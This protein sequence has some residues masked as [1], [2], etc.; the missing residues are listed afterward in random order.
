[1]AIRV[2]TPAIQ[3]PQQLGVIQAQAT[4]TPFQNL[5]LPDLSFNSRMLAQVGEGAARLGQYLQEQEDERLLLELQAGLGAW[6]RETLYGELPDGTSDATGGI[7]GLEGPD[8]FGVTERVG[9]SFDEQLAQFNE[10]LSGLSARGRMA[11]RQYAQSRRESMLDRATRF[12]FEQRE[13][14]NRQLR[15]QALA[16]AQRAAATSWASDEELA[17]AETRIRSAAE[18]YFT[19]EA[20]AAEAAR[21]A[22]SAVEGGFVGVYAQADA[23]E[24]ATQS[25]T[26]Q[27]DEM[28]ATEID[29]FYRQTIRTALLEGSSASVARARQIFDQ[30]VERGVIR[31]SGDDD[32][33]IR[34]VRFGEERDVT[35]SLATELFAQYPDDV[36]SAIEAVRAMRVPGEQEYYIIEELQRRYSQADS[37]AQQQREQTYDELVQQAR[38]GALVP[39]DPRLADLTDAQRNALDNLNRGMALV[40]DPAT[41]RML[42]D[43]ALQGETALADIELSDIEGMLDAST[44]ETWRSRITAA[45]NAAAGEPAYE[46]TGVR[47]EL[48]TTNAAITARLAVEDEAVQS[49]LFLLFEDEKQRRLAAGETWDTRAINEYA[50]QLGAEIPIS[51]GILGTTEAPLYQVLLGTV[52]Y[53]IRVPGVPEEAVAQIAQLLAESGDQVTPERIQEVYEEA[54]R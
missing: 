40:N 11:A 22:E 54:T 20:V 28:V 10:S 7:L 31:L 46:W 29:G 3:G 38:S 6:E 2:P 16:S 27:V 39:T 15:A 51:R 43:A 42:N 12:E 50:D 48:A 53:T 5:T 44:F 9:Q 49:D 26:Q 34:D 30:G 13:A 8:A 41:V 17:A 24:A 21:S 18:S 4:D 1:M 45:R 36:G 52:E 19:P 25:I 33:L 35:M 32:L 47:T 37:V 23:A 14:Y